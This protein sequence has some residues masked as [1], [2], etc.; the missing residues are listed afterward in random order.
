M[1]GTACSSNLVRL[2]LLDLS[3]IVRASNVL[4]PQH[5]APDTPHFG[6]MILTVGNI[7]QLVCAHMEYV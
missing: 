7:S 5:D 6:A 1:G 3:L 2:D 4:R